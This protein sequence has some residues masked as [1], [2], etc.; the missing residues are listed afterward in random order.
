L[1]NRRG[2]YLLKRFAVLCLAMAALVAVAAGCGGGSENGGGSSLSKAEYEAKMQ[3]L[4]DDL[5]AAADSLRNVNPTDLGSVSDVFNQATDLYNKAASGLADINPPE[6]IAAAHQKLED[7]LQTAADAFQELN[8]KVKD[9]TLSDLPDVLGDL[10][11]SDIA[12][13]AAIQDAIDEIK[14]KGYDLGSD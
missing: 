13:I 4:G 7:G 1:D 5:N 2:R 6:E 11:L 3:A 8:D 9:A 10:N 12:G 14:S